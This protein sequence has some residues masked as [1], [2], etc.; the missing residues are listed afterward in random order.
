M[1]KPE[2]IPDNVILSARRAWLTADDGAVKDWKKA[3]AAAINAWPGA[4]QWT[5]NGPLS[6]NGY[7]LPMPQEKNDD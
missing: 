7:I 4:F 2:Q 5:F 1:I 3:I 6:G